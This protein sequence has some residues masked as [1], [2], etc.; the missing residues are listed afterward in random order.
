VVNVIVV[1]DQPT[2]STV[3]FAAVRDYVAIA[4]GTRRIRVD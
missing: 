1:D 2:V 3:S 4:L